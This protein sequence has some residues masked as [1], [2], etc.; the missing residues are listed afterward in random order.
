V[1]ERYFEGQNGQTN[2]G[3]WIVFQRLLEALPSRCIVL[4]RVT[5]VAVHERMEREARGEID[6]VVV[7]PMR[8]VMIVEV[9]SGAEWTPELG[10]IDKGNPAQDP[11]TQLERNRAWL[12]KRLEA[13]RVDG[14]DCG[15]V[16]C[17]P[18]TTHASDPGLGPHRILLQPTLLGEDMARFFERA[19]VSW[20]LTRE[21]TTVEVDRIVGLLRPQLGPRAEW[22]ADCAAVE[23]EIGR[24]TEQQR[25]VL[26]AILRETSRVA[27]EGC[28][29]SGKTM[30]ALE[31][32]RRFGREGLNVL[33]LCYNEQLLAY[34]RLAQM[35]DEAPRQ[36]EIHNFFSL[37]ETIRAQANR[38][39]RAGGLAI[40][41]PERYYEDK[42]EFNQLLDAVQYADRPY[43]A[44]I[45]DEGQDLAPDW[46]DLAAGLLRDEAQGRLI[47]F[48][49]GAQKLY[50]RGNPGAVIAAHG[51][52]QESLQINCRNPAPVHAAAM[53]Y[54]RNG[55]KYVALV[56]EGPVP[57][58]LEYARSAQPRKAQSACLTEWLRQIRPAGRDVVVLVPHNTR[59]MAE[60]WPEGMTVAGYEITHDV[61]AWL[62][63]GNQK[64]ILASTAHKFKGL[65]ARYV[66]VADLEGLP[67]KADR[68]ARLY[69]ALS[70]A[71]Y[72]LVLVWPT[73]LRV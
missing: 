17:L 26:E 72:Q 39:L 23:A 53:R 10:W 50:E 8:G 30:L 33:L 14:V 24:A 58:R 9:K 19:F 54:H 43:D 40:P 4:P 66:V 28:A 46:I 52:A 42:G 64:R 2:R 7:D 48:Y 68:E 22:R 69:T 62:A 1:T 38:A 6:F 59:R 18:N 57:A 20:D 63:A 73:G 35:S 29:G 55:A 51:L 13:A 15:Y 65:E 56:R 49:D 12:S 5:W 60:G 45:I 27:V 25:R 36:V 31:A 41:R 16:L 37:A 67:E 11:R 70:R 34:L 71:T 47:L 3:E 21:M 61:S 32:A 44:V